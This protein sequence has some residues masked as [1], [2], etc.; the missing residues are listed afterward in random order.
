MRTGRLLCG[1]AL[2]LAIGTPAFAQQAAQDGAAERDDQTIIVTATRREQTLQEVPISVAVVG[3]EQL[4]QKGTLL[5]DDVAD[6]VPNLQ[7][8]RTNGNFAITM[9][10]LGAGTGN[11]RDILVPPGR[12]KGIG[13]NQNFTMPVA[14]RF[15]GGAGHAARFRLGIGGDSIF[16]I[17]N[18]SVSRQRPGLFQST[19]I[20]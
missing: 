13:A 6:G 15:G 5:F 17:E 12:C 3:G 16:K 11:L 4:E 14:A 10:G 19:R 8:D 18:Q 9:R 20:R 7:I 2:A 1:A